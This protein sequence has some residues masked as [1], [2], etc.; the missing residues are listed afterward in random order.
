MTEQTDRTISIPFSKKQAL[1]LTAALAA[2]VLT[3]FCFGPVEGLPE[4][5]QR[6]IA[7]MAA[8]V[9]IW[10]T[11]ALPLTVAAMMLVMVQPLAGTASLND[12]LHNFANPV[13]FFVFGMFCFTYAFT[14]T[15]LS[16]R[17]ALWISRMAGGSPSRLVF[18]FIAGGTL[19]STVMA[20]VPV[21]IMLAPIALKIV[22]QNGCMR[23]NSNFARALMIG[24]PMGILIGGIATP[25]GSSSNILTMQ[26]LQ[27][28][29]G[30][31]ISFA[32]WTA[33][34]LP[35]ALVLIPIVWFAMIKIFPP[36]LD[37]LEGT[38]DFEEEWKKLGPMSRDEKKFAVFILVN[39]VLWFTDSIHHIPVPILA[40]IGGTALFVPG[41][42]LLNW[43]YAGPRVSWDVLTLLG[44]ACSLSMSLWNTGAA[45]W[46]GNFLLGDLLSLPL[47][48]LMLVVGFF[49][50]WIHLLVPISTPL[51]AVFMPMVIALA[52]SKGINPAT[53]ALP[54][55]FLATASFVLVI[56]AVQLVTYQYGYY[57]M[58]DWL[59]AGVAV[60]FIWIPLCVLSVLFIGGNV[61]G[62]Y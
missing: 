52:Q 9:I 34:G 36:E 60:S 10:V 58:K 15:G 49:T 48:L 37:T 42:A 25:T 4:Q 44:A 7:L 8:A 62:L 56:D 29:A 55:G 33:I 11:E 43:E 13:V 22:E 57:S 54:M 59:K 21:V 50:M 39:M 46:V 41:I 27:D 6:A 5:G 32:E 12:S 18:C 28:M 40:V 3:A 16:E 14:R 31:G 19:L 35:V 61:L 51:I 26:F 23:L 1:A 38:E 30:V 17:V 45:A 20:D 2:Y 24:L 47:W 53:L